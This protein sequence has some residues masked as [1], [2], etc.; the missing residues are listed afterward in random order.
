MIQFI[1]NYRFICEGEENK[2]GGRIGLY[3]KNKSNFKIR[4]DLGF[5]DQGVMESLFV[6]QIN[7]N[8]V[9]TIIGIIYRTPNSD[10]NSFLE[11]L[12]EIIEKVNFEGKNATYLEIIT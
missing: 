5:Y 7:D 11:K 3:I 6:E 9:N 2:T 1:E 8:N 4:K 10:I 12:T